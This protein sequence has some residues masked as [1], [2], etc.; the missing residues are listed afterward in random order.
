MMSINN[1][2]FIFQFLIFGLN[3]FIAS[4]QASHCRKCKCSESFFVST[5]FREIELVSQSELFSELSG[6]ERILAP[7][8]VSEPAKFRYM[9]VFKKLF[10]SLLK[11]YLMAPS[12]ICYWLLVFCGKQHSNSTQICPRLVYRFVSSILVIVSSFPILV[13]NS[14][15]NV[16]RN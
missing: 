10:C 4:I 6:M 2:Y 9:Y 1:F 3:I 16:S 14:V 7:N 12:I 5:M 11:K 15:F 8:E 13:N